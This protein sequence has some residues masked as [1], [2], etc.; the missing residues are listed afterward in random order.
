M[1]YEPCPRFECKWTGVTAR[2]STGM[3]AKGGYYMGQKPDLPSPPERAP[4]ED[5][6]GAASVQRGAGERARG[7]ACSLPNKGPGPESEVMSMLQLE[8]RCACASFT[9]SAWGVSATRV[10]ALVQAS[11]DLPV[12]AVA[13]QIW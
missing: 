9:Q 13:V 7:A 4:A 12:V 2:S 11:L 8:S 5:G 1:S 6:R 3:S 10:G